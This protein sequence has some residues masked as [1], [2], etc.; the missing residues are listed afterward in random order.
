MIIRQV[1]PPPTHLSPFAH[2]IFE[3]HVA[4]WISGE[5]GAFVVFLSFV[6]SD[7]FASQTFVCFGI[8]VRTGLIFYIHIYLYIYNKSMYKIWIYWC[9]NYCLCSCRKRQFTRFATSKIVNNNNFPLFS[10]FVDTINTYTTGFWPEK[11]TKEASMRS[12]AN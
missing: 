5:S 7:S 11:W 10:F 4:L 9:Y 1:V 6:A 2:L 8:D 12:V 3:V